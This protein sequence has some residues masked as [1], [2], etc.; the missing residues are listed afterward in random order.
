MILNTGDCPQTMAR[1]TFLSAPLQIIVRS[2]NWPDSRRGLKFTIVVDDGAANK[3]FGSI[4]EYGSLTPV[5][6]YPT[7][8]VASNKNH[9]RVFDSKERT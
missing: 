6:D 5:R 3:H 9:G 2:E 1:W 7:C 4:D 8:A